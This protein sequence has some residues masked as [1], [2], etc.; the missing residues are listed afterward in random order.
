MINLDIFAVVNRDDRWTR[1]GS[2][3]R[4][5]RIGPGQIGYRT[6]PLSDRFGL[7]RNGLILKTLEN[8]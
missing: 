2:I 8:I 7:V 1:I 5:S 6:L 3:R 4:I